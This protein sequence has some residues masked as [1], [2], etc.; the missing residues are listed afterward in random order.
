MPS[1]PLGVLD[2]AA[3]ADRRLDCL[4]TELTRRGFV[5]AAAAPLVAAALA[6]CGGGGGDGPVGPGTGGGT[7]GVTVS[8]NTVAIDLA[9]QPGLTA[10][11]GFLLIPEAKTVVLNVDGGYR[12]FTSVCTH[13]Q[14]DI[15]RFQGGVLVCPCHDSRFDVNGRVT[16]AAEGSGLTP[17]TQA[18]LRQYAVSAS[19]STV[20][21]TRI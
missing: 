11:G 3:P 18:P 1:R 17:Q 16:K 15:T 9:Q 4:A 13:Q 19:G 8:G 10:A 14:C 7:R 2:D 5:T 12:A 20:T 21:V 6:A